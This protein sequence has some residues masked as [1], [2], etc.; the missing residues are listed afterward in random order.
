MAVEKVFRLAVIALTPL[1]GLIEPARTSVI[2]P[3]MA[4]WK[5]EPAPVYQP[6]GSYTALKAAWM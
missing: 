3:P 5:S 6:G 2:T 4:F 1:L